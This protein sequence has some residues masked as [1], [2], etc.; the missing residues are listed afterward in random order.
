[1]VRYPYP[2]L[3]SYQS[4]WT[5]YVR[6]KILT[7]ASFDHV[8]DCGVEMATTQD[9]GQAL[10]RLLSDTGINGRSLFISPRKWAPRGYLDLDVDEYSGNNL[11]EEIQEDQLRSA[12]VDLGVF[13]EKGSK[14]SMQR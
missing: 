3:T 6:T 5:R 2:L 10:L 14:S 9:A 11:L 1:M 7:S 13:I 12:P 8:E 4:N